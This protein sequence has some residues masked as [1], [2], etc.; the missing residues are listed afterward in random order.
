[1]SGENA[2]PDAELIAL[3]H[4]ITD[5][6]QAVEPLMEGEDAAPVE[7]NYARWDALSGRAALI[8]AET[9]AGLRARLR[10]IGP[11]VLTEMP[12]LAGEPGGLRAQLVSA[13]DDLCRFAL[14]HVPAE[15]GL[16]AT[17]LQSPDAA[18]LAT[19][20]EWRANT[21]HVD[22][23]YT[24]ADDLEEADFGNEEVR[25]AAWAIRDACRPYTRRHHVLLNTLRD[26]PARTLAGLAE[27]AHTI[28][29]WLDP[30]GTTAPHDAEDGRVAWS[31][32]RDVLRMQERQGARDAALM[33]A[34]AEFD[35]L[36]YAYLRLYYGPTRLGTDEERDAAEEKL[37]RDKRQDELL[38][39]IRATRA[40]CVYVNAYPLL[41]R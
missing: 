15:D 34:C 11:V 35:R 36:E 33:A 26:T 4:E 28:L 25:A 37:A 18:I 5:L 9:L 40:F 41:A 17:L 6:N 2:S 8:P 20:S 7:A 23:E 13:A 14:G 31:L 32:A 12:R 27:K 1:M 38:Q 22:A 3:C 21:A 16:N 24:R 19:G 10:A 30:D 39:V 29:H